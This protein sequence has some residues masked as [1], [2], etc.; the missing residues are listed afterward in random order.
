MHIHRNKAD[1]TELTDFAK[2]FIERSERK[3]LSN[4]L[5]ETFPSNFHYD[6]ID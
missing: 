2:E 3:I 6:F 1:N 5:I 4:T